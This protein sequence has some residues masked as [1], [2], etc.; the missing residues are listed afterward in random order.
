M[1]LCYLDS[2]GGSLI[3]DPENYVLSSLIINEG[4][5]ALIENQM[6]SLKQ[7]HFPLLSP[8]EVEIHAK[9]MMNGEGIFKTVNFTK[10]YAILDDV[11][12]FLSGNAQIFTIESVLIEKNKLS[13]KSL[14]LELWGHRMIFERINKFLQSENINLV[15]NDNPPQFGLMIEDTE[16]EKKDQKLRK[17]VKE[18]LKNGTFYSKLDF[19]VEDPLFTDSKWRNLS[20]LVDCIAYAIRSAYGHP[21]TQWKRQKWSQ[22]FKKIEPL[23]GKCTDGSYENCGFKIFP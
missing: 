11:F 21:N 1:Y 22:Y 18:M 9:D 4:S 8:E 3:S 5:W 13:K 16:G 12:D 23:F 14:D 20:Q 17:K 19:L 6:N 2:S 7:K 10:T 15:Q